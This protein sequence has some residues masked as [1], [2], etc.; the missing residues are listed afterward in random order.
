MFENMKMATKITATLVV[1]VALMIIV[2]IVGAIDIKKIE[3]ADTRLFQKMTLP[4]EYLGEI[5]DSFQRIRVRSLQLAVAQTAE[6]KKTHKGKIDE[7][8]KKIEENIEF[9][10]DTYIDEGDRK[11]WEAFISLMQKYFEINAQYLE[12]FEKDQDK[13]AYAL[14][15]GEGAKVKDQVQEALDKIKTS[16]VDAAKATS[17]NNTKT[18]NGAITVMTIFIVIAALFAAV[19]GYFIVKN[20]A[21]IIKVFMSEMNRLIQ[22][23]VN[24][25]LDTRADTSRINFEF[26][27][28][29][30]GVNQ[31][32]DAVIG[33]LNVAAEYVDRISHGDI[34]PTIT[35]T[36]KGDF[37]EIKNNLNRCIDAVNAMSHD[38]KLLVTAA[39]EGRLDTRADA[40][41]HQGDFRVIVDGVNQTLDAVIGPLNVAAEYVDRISQGEL[42]PK[43]TD[44]YKG[45]FNEIKNNLNKMI[46]DLTKF[47]IDVQTAANQVSEGSE[48]IN[49]ASQNIAQGTNE[50]AASIEEVS[51]AME[52]MNSSVGLNADN[53]KQTAG[54]AEKAFVD[55]KE[56]G[57]AV[58]NTVKAMRNIADKISIIEEI[59]RQTNMLALNAA[60]EAARAGEHGKGFAVVAAE[61]RKLA[62][63]S[64]GAAKEISALSTSSVE[65]AERA[66][67]LLQSI[68]PGSQKTAELVNEIKVASQ[69]QSRGVNEVSKSMDE[70]N[71]VAQMNSAAV[72]EIAATSDSLN[73]QAGQ[74][75]VLAGFFKLDSKVMAG[76]GI[77]SYSNKPMINH[78]VSHKPDKKDVRKP[79][80]VKHPERA[81]IPLDDDDAD[82]AL[83]E[84]G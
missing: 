22:S 56:G 61:V 27:P 38:T 15:N 37:N 78:T 21:S 67:V 59:A 3:D 35:D 17:D 70:L 40:T 66:G 64:Q 10:K 81:I 1:L 36:Y 55:A 58:D 83:S 13:E 20:Y 52:E 54:I 71:K 18:A 68:V 30:V 8:R 23:A 16:N 32:L 51:S 79:V 26:R 75:K 50:Q 74:L 48:Q 33:P 73:K 53:A 4:I 60:I 47:A 43:I 77:S 24:G 42:P 11:T 7:Y 84:L 2:G 29:A 14:M 63:R 44:A 69:E 72:E 57:E 25:E 41:K 6:E 12:L 80:K 82:F 45:D 46:E 65:V 49:A 62:E 76:M 19:I 39:V 9:Y 34:P 31:T 5:S 28:I